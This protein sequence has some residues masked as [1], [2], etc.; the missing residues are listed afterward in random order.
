MLEGKNATLHTAVCKEWSANHSLDS[1]SYSKEQQTS[2]H[3]RKLTVYSLAHL[4]RA[5]VPGRQVH[6][7]ALLSLNGL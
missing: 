1:D 6:D 4:W 7:P 3:N 5:M 2:E